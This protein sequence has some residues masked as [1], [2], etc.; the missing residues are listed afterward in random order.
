[1]E[2]LLEKYLDNFEEII[3]ETNSVPQV[4]CLQQLSPFDIKPM[5]KTINKTNKVLVIEDGSSDFGISAEIITQL[6]ENKFNG[7]VARHGA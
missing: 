6:F 2:I 4:I 7:Q 1:M 3:N 5:L